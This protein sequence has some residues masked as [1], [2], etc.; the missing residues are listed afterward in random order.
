[1]RWIAG[2]MGRL[3]QYF[4]TATILA[5]LAL[6]VVLWMKGHLSETKALDVIAA[7]YGIDIHKTAATDTKD[8]QPVAYEDILEKRALSDM[9]RDLRELALDNAEAELVNRQRQLDDDRTK[10]NQLIDQ[11]EQRLAEQRAGAVSENL[12]DA[13]QTIESL[14]P[15]QAKEMIVKLLEDKREDEVITLLQLM[16]KDKVKRIL[17]EF[18]LEECEMLYDILKKILSG[19]GESDLIDSVQEKIDEFK[20]NQT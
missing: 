18:T 4:C 1:M 8:Q 14:R 15:D 5:L 12:K 13:A 16:Q 19:S 20:N 6:L 9:D 10:Y 3:F 2:G 11:F 7:A 17:N